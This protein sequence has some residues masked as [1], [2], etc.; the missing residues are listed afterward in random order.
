MLRMRFPVASQQPAEHQDLASSRLH[1]S[2]RSYLRRRLPDDAPVEDLLQDILVKAL[3]AD[4]AGKKIDNVVGWLYAAARTSVADYYRS[5]GEPVREVDE[6]LPA[7]EIGG[8][9]FAF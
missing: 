4:R 7:N 1:H 6:S 3:V 8:L 5:R 9:R 2:L